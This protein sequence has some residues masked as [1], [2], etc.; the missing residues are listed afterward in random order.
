[1]AMK[2]L[3]IFAITILA[4]VSLC[5]GVFVW[6]QY[7]T[8]NEPTYVFQA[9]GLGYFSLVIFWLSF[10]GMHGPW[11]QLIC[12]AMVFGI[13][14]GISW[15][16]SNNLANTLMPCFQVVAVTW[17]IYALCLVPRHLRDW[18]LGFG[19]QLA[20]SNSSRGKYSLKNILGFMFVVSIPLSLIQLMISVDAERAYSLLIQ[21]TILIGFALATVLPVAVAALAKVHAKWKMVAGITWCLFGTI[22]VAILEN[23]GVRWLRYLT[24]FHFSFW[25]I[26]VINMLAVRAIGFRWQTRVNLHFTPNPICSNHA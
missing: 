21:F 26:V 12:T 20:A 18:Q 8:R 22:T 25:F 5:A 19:Q 13:S 15:P 16:A 23:Y 10:G 14:L 2:A 4:N 17:L 1:M 11:R 6:R 7:S 24:L 3:L 9:I